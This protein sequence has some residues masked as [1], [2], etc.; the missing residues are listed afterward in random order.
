MNYILPTL[1]DIPLAWNDIF[2]GKAL[3]DLIVKQPIKGR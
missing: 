2:I 1:P 3:Y